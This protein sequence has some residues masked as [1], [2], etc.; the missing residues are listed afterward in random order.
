MMEGEQ[1]GVIPRFV[2][3]FGAGDWNL[4]GIG[5]VLSISMHRHPYRLITSPCLR[6][7]MGDQTGLGPKARTY[8]LINGGTMKERSTKEVEGK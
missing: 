5:V 1:S 4:G 7:K 6:T 3:A 2:V 8:S